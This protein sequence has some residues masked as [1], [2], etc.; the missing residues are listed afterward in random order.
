VEIAIN[1]KIRYDM[2]PV[3]S[4][5]STSTERR[6][7]EWLNLRY[8]GIHRDRCRLPRKDTLHQLQFKHCIYGGGLGTCFGYCC[9]CCCCCGCVAS[10]A[11][12]SVVTYDG[13]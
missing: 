6:N 1:N 9:C 3:F 11:V 7:C 12:V 2:I 8:V 10:E 4:W 5:D 13:F